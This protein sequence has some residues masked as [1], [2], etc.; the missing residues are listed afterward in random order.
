MRR[1]VLAALAVMGLGACVCGG[2]DRAESP[3]YE[4]GHHY[5]GSTYVECHPAYDHDSCE[6][7]FRDVCHGDY[8]EVPVDRTREFD[9][10][11]DDTTRVAFCRD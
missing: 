5:G 1:I 6:D 4:P 10:D 3:R 9:R 7:H 8:D 11:A 2:G